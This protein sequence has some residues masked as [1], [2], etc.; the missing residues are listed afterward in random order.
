M[1]S[2]TQ[3]AMVFAANMSDLWATLDFPMATTCQECPGIPRTHV[4]VV[5]SFV[6]ACQLTSATSVEAPL[7]SPL[8]Q[9]LGIVRSITTSVRFCQSSRLDLFNDSVM[10]SEG[11]V[12]WIS[13]AKVNSSQCRLVC[14]SLACS[15]P[16]DLPYSV[17]IDSCNL[18][19]ETYI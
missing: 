2:N 11:I 18:Q 4:A 12:F 8:P 19:S 5:N 15:L 10:F 13:S 9:G 17:R 6:G 1:V 16:Q 3:Q 14:R 7:T